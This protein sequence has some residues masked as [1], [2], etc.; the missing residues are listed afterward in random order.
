MIEVKRGARQFVWVITTAVTLLFAQHTLAAGTLAGVTVANQAQVDYEVAAVAQELILSDPLGNSI[1]GAGSG[2]DTTDFLVDNRVDFTIV[3]FGLIGA[4]SVF[5]G[6]DDA[7]TTF[8]LTNTGN[9][10]Q[11][12]ALAAA[13]LGIGVIVNGNTDTVDM[14]GVEVYSDTDG[15]LDFSVADLTFVD[16][17]DPDLSILIFIVADA[18]LA[19]LDL[20]VANVE[21]TATTHDSGTIG[22]LDALTTDDSAIPDSTTTVEVVFADDGLGAV[23]DGIETQRDGYIVSSAALTITKTSAV[24]SDPFNL[25]VNPKAIPGAVVEYTITVQ[26]NGAVDADQVAITDVLD[27]SLT[28]LLG[29]YAGE[30]VEIDLGGGTTVTTCTLDAADADGDGCGIAGA[31]LTIDPVGGLTVGILA[32]N[33]PGVIKFQATIN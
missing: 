21:L 18:G 24:L 2:A 12:Y 8:Q 5:P 14:G 15:S 20:D 9:E 6:Q 25:A 33:N 19:L 30:D 31:T 10:T 27:A 23:G 17:L 4:T 26:N 32:T 7:V 28:I 16:E 29:Q 22:T 11:D 1:P 3:E 13:N